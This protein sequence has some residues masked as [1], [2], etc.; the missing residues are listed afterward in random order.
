MFVQPLSTSLASYWGD[1]V[2]ALAARE[3]NSANSDDDSYFHIR[4][5]NRTDRSF[6]LH[7]AA[8]THGRHVPHDHAT[9]GSST[10]P[11]GAMAFA[12]FSLN[13]E[14]LSRLWPFSGFSSAA[15]GCVVLEDAC[16]TD[17]CV[18][19]SFD[20]PWGDKAPKINLRIHSP[21]AL[22]IRQLEEAL[23][24]ATPLAPREHKIHSYGRNDGAR[25]AVSVARERAFP[26]ASP[27]SSVV[28]TVSSP[29][30]M[31][32]CV[33][34]L[35]RVLP[36]L[37]THLIERVAFV[38]SHF[39]E[40]VYGGSVGDSGDVFEADVV[41]EHTQRVRRFM[42]PVP[43]LLSQALMQQG[44][45]SD[46]PN[47]V[48]RCEA[49]HLW[50]ATC[51]PNSSWQCKV[52]TPSRETDRP[53]DV[54]GIDVRTDNN[55]RTPS[56]FT[57][58]EATLVPLS[59]YRSMWFGSIHVPEQSLR[60][61]L[62][63]AHPSCHGTDVVTLTTMTAADT[64]QERIVLSLVI[65]N[66]LGACSVHRGCV[67]FDG[68]AAPT[69]R[70]RVLQVVVPE[71]DRMRMM[72]KR[73][74][75]E[76][77]DDGGGG[78]HM[79]RTYDVRGR[80]GRLLGRLSTGERKRDPHGGSERDVEDV[81]PWAHKWEFRPAAASPLSELEGLAVCLVMSGLS[82]YAHSEACTKH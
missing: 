67:F 19:L 18:M 75:R 30:Q 82:L 25:Y 54:T 63:R 48:W 32:I 44:V 27:N 13:N 74:E 46:S 59:T 35:Q 23:S 43:A 10:V 7:S 8:T 4:I 38:H 53:F 6:R 42:H 1:Y 39:R 20:V 14:T 5:I 71:S 26:T 2:A 60:L 78:M 11:A 45:L 80:R 22:H 33:D 24:V 70:T 21:G 58:A 81:T 56:N 41:E 12:T 36:Y 28:V 3:H 64:Q 47:N 16:A 73:S 15:R 66:D 76:R 69:L 57:I 50:A 49:L 62:L 77:N 34:A 65:L 17:V 29:H 9:C 51:T 37:E 52:V 79:P 68:R 55:G 31:R 72:L 61:S 40:A